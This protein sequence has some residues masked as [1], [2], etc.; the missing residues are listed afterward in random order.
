MTEEEKY[1]VEELLKSY[2]P[3]KSNVEIE[4]NVL[5][6][7]YFL[8]SPLFV[9]CKNDLN[10]KGSITEKLAINNL[11]L[12]SKIKQKAQVVLMI[13]SALNCLPI[14]DEYLVKQR[15]FQNKNYTTIAEQIDRHRDTVSR[16]VNKKILPKLIKTGILNAWELFEK[17]GPNH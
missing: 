7:D 9:E 15:F 11:D 3:L 8:K 6:P 10:D 4:I 5:Y 13:H 2:Q 12:P 16:R 14:R 17:T 1:K